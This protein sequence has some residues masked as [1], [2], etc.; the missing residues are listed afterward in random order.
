M[1]AYLK[2]DPNPCYEGWGPCS[3]AHGYGHTCGRGGAHKGRCRCSCGSTHRPRAAGNTALVGAVLT[4][5]EGEP[6]VVEHAADALMAVFGY[7]RIA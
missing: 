3:M 5:S 6:E 4:Y 1:T 2:P 7:K